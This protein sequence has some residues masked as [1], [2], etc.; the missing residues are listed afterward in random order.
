[1]KAETNAAIPIPA[2]SA[3]FVIGGTQESRD[4]FTGMIDEVKLYNRGL[5]E[6]EVKSAL[7]GPETPVAPAG[8]LAI[9]WGR[10]KS[11]K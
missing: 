8:K 11:N 10:I 7:K 2:N 3:T 9:T 4:W 6:A 1:V 5:T